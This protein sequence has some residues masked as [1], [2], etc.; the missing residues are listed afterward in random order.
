MPEVQKNKGV[1]DIV[2]VLDATGSMTPCINALKD[3]IQ[4]FVTS[5]T[6]KDANNSTPIKDWRAKVLGYRDFHFDTVPIVDNPF[7]TRAEELRDQLA[8]LHADGGG[9]EPESLLEA[10]YLVAT[11]P[12]SGKGE[13]P[14]PDAWRHRSAAARVVVVFTDASYKEPLQQPKGAVFEDVYNEL[15][16]NRIILSLFAPDLPCYEK[17]SEVDRAEW[18]VVSGGANPQESLALYTTDQRN[19]AQTLRQL[20]KTISKSAEVMSVD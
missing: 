4:T 1:V 6:T 14:R 18:N 17:L 5:L 15:I 11:M 7:V 3:N 9:D 13:P 8:A 2:F 12:A 19:F 10:I 16:S 20:A